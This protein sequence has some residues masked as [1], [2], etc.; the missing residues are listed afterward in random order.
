MAAVG[1]PETLAEALEADAGVP[2]LTYDLSLKITHS[3]KLTKNK[4]PDWA[5]GQAAK[6]SL[7]DL[8]LKPEH[9]GLRKSTI[10]HLRD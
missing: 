1:A 6:C 3:M 4:K 2:E 9:Q 10:M 5:T 8:P 7:A